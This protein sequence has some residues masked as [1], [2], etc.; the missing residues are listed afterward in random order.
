MEPLARLEKTSLLPR[1]AGE[2]VLTIAVDGVFQ[3]GEH[4]TPLTLHGPAATERRKVLI[5]QEN[6][7]FEEPAA[8]SALGLFAY[9]H[10][11]PF[12]MPH[13]GN[14]ARLRHTLK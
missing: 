2:R 14:V 7:W 1:V 8:A 11:P 13:C 4:E 10:R 6:I 3:Y 9:L 5:R 12:R